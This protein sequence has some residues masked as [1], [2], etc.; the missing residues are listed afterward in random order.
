MGRTIVSVIAGYALVALLAIVTDQVAALMIPGFEKMVT[1][2][3]YYFYTTL[4]TDTLY[5]FVAGYLCAVIARMHTRRSTI[6]LVVLGEVIGIATQVAFWKVIPHWFALALL[7][8]FPLAVWYGSKL[9]SR[10]N[11]YS[12]PPDSLAQSSAR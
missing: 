12:A 5:A 4:V 7:V 2:P 3:P 6:G 11:E 9:R 8:T 1:P 10:K